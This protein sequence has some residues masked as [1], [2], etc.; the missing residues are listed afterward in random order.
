MFN[1]AGLLHVVF[2]NPYLDVL[3]WP[4]FFCGIGIQG[5]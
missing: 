1:I 3:M 2:S 5:D 4:R